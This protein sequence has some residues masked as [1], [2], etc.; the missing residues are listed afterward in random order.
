MT[1]WVRRA[2]VGVLM[3]LIGLAG[4]QV[5]A[6]GDGPVVPLELLGGSKRALHF[7]DPASRIPE[8]RIKRLLR[9]GPIL[10]DRVLLSNGVAVYFPDGH[11]VSAKVEI[12]QFQPKGD[13]V[14]EQIRH[15][16][17]LEA[18][19]LYAKVARF[20]KLLGPVCAR[21]SDVD[22]PDSEARLRKDRRGVYSLEIEKPG[23]F[24]KYTGQRSRSYAVTSA[25]DVGFIDE[26]QLVRKLLIGC[27]S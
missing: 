21:L 4:P 12:D 23:R 27:R 22:G 10:G 6:A 26:T 16:T 24:D 5:R 19:T 2:V 13:L 9:T 7:N 18:S 15:H 17:H 1:A 20:D 14:A 25:L 11:I 3:A 8:S